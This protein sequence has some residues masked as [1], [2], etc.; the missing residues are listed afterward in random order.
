M[1]AEAEVKAA[2]RLNTAADSEQ[3][4]DDEARIEWRISEL[5]AK[6]PPLTDAQ[7]A[8]L[9]HAVTPSRSAGSGTSTRSGSKT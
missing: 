6:L 5:L 2:L 1:T 3:D 9:R 7:V 4:Q 8:R